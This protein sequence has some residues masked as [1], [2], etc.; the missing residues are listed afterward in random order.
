ML[1]TEIKGGEAE[2]VVQDDELESV[3]TSTNMSVD[4]AEI[5]G[6]PGLPNP[7]LETDFPANLP[8]VRVI[9][10]G[11]PGIDHPS[12]VAGGIRPTA[13]LFVL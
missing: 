1:N 2:M 5:L 6:E 7:F 10:S 8:N 4:M 13:D 3:D 11:T 12:H 9:I